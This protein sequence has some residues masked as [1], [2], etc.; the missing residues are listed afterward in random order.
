MDIDE[1]MLAVA[2]GAAAVVSEIARY[3][4]IGAI[5]HIK[6]FHAVRFLSLQR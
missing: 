2:V 5:K 4:H 6:F 1:R 3:E